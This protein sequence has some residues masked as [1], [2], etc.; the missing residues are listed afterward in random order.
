LA[1]VA[2]IRSR[3]F[4]WPGALGVALS[5][6]LL[7]WALHGVSLREVATHLRAVR[8]LPFLGA[9]VLAT[10]TFPLRTIR[11]RSLL[12]M[13]GTK[14]PLIPLWHAT[15]IGFMA[16]NLLPARAGEV[17]RAY[18]VR[19][20]TG[21]RFTAAMG[22]VVVERAFDGIML[23]GL[24]VAGIALGGFAHGGSVGGVALVRVAAV[25]AVVFVPALGL[26]FWLVHWPAPALRAARWGTERLLPRR[27]A[28]RAVSLLE[29]TLAG[30]DALKSPRRLAL[31]VAWSVVLW[32]VSAASYWVGCI[33]LG[34][35]VPA[36][37]ALLLQGLIALGAALPSSPGFF[38]PFEA[39]ARATL[40]LYGVAAPEAVTYAVA[41]HLAVFVPITA[42]GL[43]SLSRAHLHM[44]DLSNAAS[45][46]A[47]AGTEATDGSAG[48]E[49]AR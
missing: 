30:F 8:P 36:S 39:V 35:Q 47:S 15:A 48:A 6:L 25:A 33:A 31:V 10:A 16:N 14:L 7:W 3:R 4:G 27:W 9:V 13:G 42:L 24:L 32:L 46:A 37:A 12:Q 34:L 29:G 18:A 43:W 45:A 38:G 44:T 5:V 21:V 40:S 20:L 11:W 23:V 28:A 1:P 2:P 17:A 22:S 19:R 26:A 41:Y 49:V